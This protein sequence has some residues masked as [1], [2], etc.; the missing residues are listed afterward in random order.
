MQIVSH[1]Q[2]TQK[3]QWGRLHTE[4]AAS[5]PVILTTN[6]QIKVIG[7]PHA[8]AIIVLNKHFISA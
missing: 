7:R 2:I 5:S 6:R 3:R 1:L 4:P 8:A